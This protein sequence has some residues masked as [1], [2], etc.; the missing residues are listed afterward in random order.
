[1][2]TTPTS[3]PAPKINRIG[4]QVLD[5]R[6][7]KT[8]LCAGCGHNAISERIIDAMYEM[9]VKPE[10]VAKLSGI[11][12]SS[13]SPAY[14]MSRSHSFNAV[15]GRMP[16]V[17]T[18]ATLANRNLLTLGVSGDGDTASIGVGQFVHLMRRNL[19]IIYIIE[20]NGVYGLTKGQF[21]ATADVGSKLKTG[22]I[23]DLPP[24]DTCALAVSL[25]A[26]FVGRSFSGDK[27]Q[28]HAM[29]K[30][31]IAHQGTVMLDVVSPCV[32]FNDH[33][34]STK[35]YKYMKDHDEPLHEMDFVPAFQDIN[36]D[37][38]P[39]TTM[40]VTMH[41]GSQLRLRKLEEDYDPTDKIGAVKRMM[42]AHEK[43]EVLTGVLY[44][45]TKAPSFIEMLNVID[46]PLATLPENI[47]RPGREVLDEVM[48]QLR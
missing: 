48:E 15:H 42:E 37:Y 47:V 30:A 20:D 21:S 31:A 16:S 22:V 27:R 17:A 24:I 19:P 38:D 11:G 8:T 33:E 36:V 35:S 26:T 45:D 23:N 7:G 32:T 29:L 13:K 3:T 6:G 46:E 40:N 41:D 39:G 44:L 14:F 4:L 1:M 5:Y 25:G 9:G 2:A 43:N 18:G 12:C 34:G 10:R 28:L